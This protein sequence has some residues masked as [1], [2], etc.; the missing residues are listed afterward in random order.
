MSDSCFFWLLEL[1]Q[2]Q[3]LLNKDYGFMREEVIKTI[4]FS[5][6]KAQNLRWE[7]DKK[8]GVRK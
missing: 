8:K 3:R 2:S 1:I 7:L 4:I 5:L 6:N